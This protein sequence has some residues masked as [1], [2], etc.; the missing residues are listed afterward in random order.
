MTIIQGSE[1][2]SPS[3]L[4][5]INHIR[6]R[7]LDN[8]NSL[9]NK[10][11]HALSSSVPSIPLVDI[12]AGCNFS[13]NRALFENKCE[14]SA[15]NVSKLSKKFDQ[16]PHESA[17][18]QLNS[19]NKRREIFA[20]NRNISADNE[21]KPTNLS[22][23]KLNV[24]SVAGR[25]MSVE[26]PTKFQNQNFNEK[27]STASL[28]IKSNQSSNSSTNINSIRVSSGSGSTASG[29]SVSAVNSRPS[30]PTPSC[31]SPTKAQQVFSIFFNRL[32]HILTLLEYLLSIP[33]LIF[34]ILK[35]NIHFLAWCSTTKL[36]KYS[37][38]NIS[39]Y[40]WEQE[41]SNGILFIIIDSGFPKLFK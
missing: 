14:L 24:N 2:P 22:W 27:S 6:S 8:V 23:S 28:D 32:N 34:N 25:G 4:A 9:P 39:F 11:R 10:V 33:C 31:S 13:Q 3:V 5:R 20:S 12:E 1:S 16:Q 30:S 21:P 19:K 40:S 41:K 15:N 37:I 7:E 38:F 29:S 18:K 35:E 17:C 36:H 26:S